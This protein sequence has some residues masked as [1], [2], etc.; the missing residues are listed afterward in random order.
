M[1]R[2]TMRPPWRRKGDGGCRAVTGEGDARQMDA[3]RGP[4]AAGGRRLLPPGPIPPVSAR[5]PI[6]EIR[7]RRR[8]LPPDL[9]ADPAYAIDSESWRTYLS[10]ETDSRRRAGFMGDRDFPFD[11]PPPTRP[12]RQQAPPRAQ[13]NGDDDHDNDEYDDYDD[14]DYIEALAYHNVEVKD[15]SDDYVAAVFHEW[16]QA[17]AEG[18]TFDFP[19]NMTDDEMAK[20]G[21]LVSENDAPVQLPLPARHGVMP[22]GCRR[23]K[24]C[25]GATGLGRATPRRTTPG[26]SSRRI[27]GRLHRRHAA[28]LSAS[29]SS[30]RRAGARPDGNWPWV[31]PE[32]IV[33]DIDEEQQ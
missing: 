12:R 22:P 13:Y 7:R 26:S 27:P 30:S 6:G 5:A 9:R 4:A 16:Q 14:D 28:S 20:L 3:V 15:D 1:G 11:R 23:M 17:M 10:T 19:E 18:R 8:Y 33:L 2:I 25:G 32:L 31:I 24:R 21:V 29:T